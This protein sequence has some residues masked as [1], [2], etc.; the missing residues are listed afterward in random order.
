MNNEQL[1]KIIKNNLVFLICFIVL[2]MMYI[3]YLCYEIYIDSKQIKMP[4]ITKC[5]DYW[6]YKEDECST[7]SININGK[8]NIPTN[9]T[10]NT[11][12]N[13]IKT[14]NKLWDGS[15]NALEGLK[16]KCQWAKT[17]KISWDSLESSRLCN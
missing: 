1:G 15:G 9:A 8:I 12:K 10:C 2:L 6:T 17:H 13:C 16:K 14:S 3:V 4:Y 7:T 11:N 5:P